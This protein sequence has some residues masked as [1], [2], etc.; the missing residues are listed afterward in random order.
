MIFNKTKLDGA[1]VIEPERLEDHRGFFA[2]VWCENEFSKHGLNSALLQCN[3]AFNY[4]KDILR[5]MHYQVA[6]YQEVKLVRCTQGSIF[7]VIVDL[8]PDSS[9]YK[10]WVGVELNAENRHMLYVPE[11][12]AHGYLTLQDN[13]EVF[14]QV[15]QAYTPEAERGLRWDDPAF[16]IAW[17]YTD[18]LTISGKD[19]AWSY[20]K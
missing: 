11:G 4:K 19:K 2:R 3:I 6:P 10:D 1:Y 5:G 7:D 12:F 16:N 9:S 13:S 20:Y 15:S 18:D 14:Y 8:R 17:P